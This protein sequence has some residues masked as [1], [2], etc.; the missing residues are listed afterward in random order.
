MLLMMR[1]KFSPL[2]NHQGF[3][4]IEIMI[5]AVILFTA[6]GV[7]A[8]VY[9]NALS[10]LER[11]GIVSIIGT[12]LPQIRIVLKKELVAGSLE[13]KG[14]YGDTLLFSWK[15]IPLKTSRNVVSLVEE[16]GSLIEYGDY[17]LYLSSVDLLLTY[18]RG[19]TLHDES[20]TYE[21]FYYTQAA[22]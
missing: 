7:G 19:K 20:Y 16:P 5:S 3:S 8:Q 18:H 1:K 10:N 9:R 2:A 13:G 22:R 21:E 4:L 11:V 14:T 6:V 12:A 15:A 17:Q